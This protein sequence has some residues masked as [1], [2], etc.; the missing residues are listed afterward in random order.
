MTEMNK[1]FS[2]PE[3]SKYSEDPEELFRQSCI[4][5]SSKREELSVYE[6]AFAEE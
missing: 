4:D 3:D 1:E 6:Q 2:Y 5:M